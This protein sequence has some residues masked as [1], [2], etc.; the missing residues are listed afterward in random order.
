MAAVRAIARTLNRLAPARLLAVGWGKGAGLDTATL[1]TRAAR[2]GGSRAGVRPLAQDAYESAGIEP[3][4]EE[5]LRDPIVQQIM[6]AD[7]VEA[8]EVRRM[9]RVPTGS[10]TPLV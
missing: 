2:R 8:A 5:M 10:P 9:L 6:R 3:H 4:L 7:S 1:A